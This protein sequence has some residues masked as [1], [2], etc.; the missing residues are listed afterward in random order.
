M[1]MNRW[2]MAGIGV[3]VAAMAFRKQR[4]CRHRSGEEHYNERD[5][6]AAKE[7]YRQNSW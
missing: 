7:E 1:R 3:G 6:S 5:A 4:S 2:M